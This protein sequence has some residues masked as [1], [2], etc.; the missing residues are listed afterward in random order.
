MHYIEGLIRAEI[1]WLFLLRAREEMHRAS[2]W[3]KRDSYA[4][5]Y[6]NAKAWE[7]ER[8]FMVMYLMGGEI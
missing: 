2:K 7:V 4:A 8:D 1:S 5:M 3:S 6:S